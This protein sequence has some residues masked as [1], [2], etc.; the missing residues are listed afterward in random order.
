MGGEVD[1]KRLQ[2]DAL[3]IRTGA[4]HCYDQR[5]R[6]STHPTDLPIFTKT[7]HCTYIWRLVASQKILYCPNY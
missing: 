6:A 5:V 2:E 1:Y 3:N 4:G 7:A